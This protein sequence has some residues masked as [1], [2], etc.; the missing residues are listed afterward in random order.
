MATPAD[1][2]E[3]IAQMTAQ[4][5]DYTFKSSISIDISA[6]LLSEIRDNVYNSSVSLDFIDRSIVTSDLK[7]SDIV[8]HTYNSSNSL[9]F[10]DQGMIDL[11][12][13][14]DT[15]ANNTAGK[16][17][18]AGLEQDVADIKNITANQ[19]NMLD[20]IYDILDKS[21]KSS[22]MNFAEVQS[23]LETGKTSGNNNSGDKKKGPNFKPTL[24]GFLGSLEGG[25][26]TSFTEVTKGLIAA[27]S[28]IKKAI[29]SGD[30]FKML[31]MAITSLAS[32]PS[33]FM[34]IVAWASKFVAAID[35]ALMARLSL[36]ISDLMA[37]V[38]KGLRPIIIFAV[39]IIRKFADALL[40]VMNALVPV[41]EKLGAVLLSAALP[42]INIWVNAIYSMIP[43]IDAFIPI[44]KMVSETMAFFAIIANL[45]SIVLSKELQALA[46]VVVTVVTAFKIV[47][48]SVMDLASQ[49]LSYIPIYG[50]GISEAIDGVNNS[51]AESAAEGVGD[52][53][54]IAKELLNPRVLAPA[55]KEGGSLGMAAK[56]ASFAG[57]ADLGKNM[58][59]A[60]FGAGEGDIQNKQL[61][62]QKIA[63]NGIGQIVGF[64]QQNLIGQKQQGVR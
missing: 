58:M 46:L 19:F 13:K 25:I 40:P 63:A 42:V 14:I 3:Q 15:V 44:L 6:S 11:L 37:V 38:G 34:G 32:I 31:D 10:L 61:E 50:K 26:I 39:K 55:G 12:A 51:L 29:E 16:S 22:N 60:A 28:A 23:L 18:S 24:S 57:I 21:W 53:S 9:A 49:I 64:F 41:M 54:K 45:A 62:Q 36:A 7:L 4:V 59:Q 20:L 35:P 5:R 43:V 27:G 33:I 56:Q 47:I 52:I 2:L 48:I 8:D 1:N 30:P 17:V